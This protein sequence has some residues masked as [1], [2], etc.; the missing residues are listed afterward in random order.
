MKKEVEPVARTMSKDTDSERSAASAGAERDKQR[1]RSVTAVRMLSPQSMAVA[2]RIGA[3]VK[4]QHRVR[5]CLTRGGPVAHD[6][7]G[8]GPV[9]GEGHALAGDGATCQGSHIQHTDS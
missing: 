6:D 2:G 7:S 8:I 3:Q 1:D 4:H 5:C 9:G